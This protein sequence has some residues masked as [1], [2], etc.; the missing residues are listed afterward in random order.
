MGVS[1]IQGLNPIGLLQLTISELDCDR[2]LISQPPPTTTLQPRSAPVNSSNAATV[3]PIHQGHQEQC[4]EMERGRK[5]TDGSRRMV[6]EYTA[7]SQKSGI[8]EACLL[9]AMT[10]PEVQKFGCK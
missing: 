5:S 1:T 4:M 2:I 7:C 8:N 10:A 3:S 6:L 9:F